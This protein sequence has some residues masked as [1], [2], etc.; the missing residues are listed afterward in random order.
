MSSDG[1]RAGETEL[2][3]ARAHGRLAA[4]LTLVHA[5]YLASLVVRDD[6][7]TGYPFTGGDTFDYLRN[8]LALAGADLDAT[9]RPPLLPLVMAALDGAGLLGWLPALFVLAQQAFALA[10]FVELAPASRV[11]AWSAWGV[12]A[13]GDPSLRWASRLEPSLLGGC[14][15]AASILLLSGRW[16][17]ASVAPWLSGALAGAAYLLHQLAL[18]YPAVA[19]LAAA[20]GRRR[21]AARALLAFLPFPAVWLAVR[22]IVFDSLGD[23]GVSHWGLIAWHTDAVQAYLAVGLTLLGVPLA[24]VALCGL[25][26]G[27]RAGEATIR[28]SAAAAALILLFFVFFY[29]FMTQRF[30]LYVLPFAVLF[31]AR[32]LA[33]IRRPVAVAAGVLLV[34]TAMLPRSAD[35]R[36]TSIP[37]LPGIDLRADVRLL[38]RAPGPI[39]RLRLT[40]R[41]PAVLGRHSTLQ[42]LRQGRDAQPAASPWRPPPSETPADLYLLAPG[43]INTVALRSRVQVLLERRV[44]LVPPQVA[45]GLACALEPLPAGDLAGVTVWRA[46]LPDGRVTTLSHRADWRPLDGLAEGACAELAGDLAAAAAGLGVAWSG[47][48]V[49]LVVDEIDPRLGLTLFSITGELVVVAPGQ[50][51]ATRRLVRRAAGGRSDFEATIDGITWR[52]LIYPDVTEI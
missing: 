4:G 29:G 52:V 50:E 11:A 21:A 9:G 26:L 23:A 24:A 37:L 3:R 38:P 39:E 31:A 47:R 6:F 34:W 42:R 25:V 17:K 18:I 13:L 7:V 45:L 32:A 33:A 14:L 35:D 12:L 51:P 22:A 16:S 28:L 8:A 5:G 27:L 30:L 40:P 36:R 15:L 43:E 41:S 2:S 1:S 49:G 44:H 46:R 48:Q 19:V 10:V 20:L